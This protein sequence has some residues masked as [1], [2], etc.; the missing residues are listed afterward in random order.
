MT[1]SLSPVPKPQ[2]EMD[3]P[4]ALQAVMDG[5]KITRKLWN[6]EDSVVKWGGFLSLRKASGQMHQLLVSDG[7]LHG[8]DWIVVREN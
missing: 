1:A 5:K 4:T 2:E 8:T 7:D 3:F 6:N